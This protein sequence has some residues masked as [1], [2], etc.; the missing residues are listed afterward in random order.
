MP[1]A[2]GPIIVLAIFV[3]VAQRIGG[4]QGL[5]LQEMLHRVGEYTLHYEE[6]FLIVLSDE[7]YEQRLFARSPVPVT[8]R[9]ITSEMMFLWVSNEK[10]WLAVRNVLMVDGRSANDSA[11]RLDRLLRSD[12]LIGI[13]KLRRI[14][15]ESARFNLGTIHRNFNDPMFPLRFFEPE[16]QQRFVFSLSGQRTVSGIA[17]S[18]LTF[19]EAASPTFIQDDGRDL[20]SHGRVW[21]GPDGAILRTQLQVGDAQ[22]R[23]TGSIVVDYVREPKLA[24]LVP[25]GMREFYSATPV[26]G[27][28]ERIEGEA[29]YSNFRQFLTSARIV[30]D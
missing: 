25:V 28:T 10:T 15:D 19:D 30:P 27:V 7:Q 12:A 23:L 6:R 24:M 21:S 8:S 2:I 4:A 22:A 9:T 3:A 13:K 17:G 18:M 11:E 26:G 20:P 1:R 14:R 16:N 29:R 5:P